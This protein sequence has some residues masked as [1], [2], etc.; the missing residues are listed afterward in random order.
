MGLAFDLN[1][2]CPKRHSTPEAKTRSVIPLSIREEERSNNTMFKVWLQKNAYDSAQE[3]RKRHNSAL[4]MQYEWSR[5]IRECRMS[6][7]AYRD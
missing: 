2:Q 5:D 3:P 6:A 7:S 4:A 1:Y